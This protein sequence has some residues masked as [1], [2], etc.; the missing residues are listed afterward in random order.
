VWPIVCVLVGCVR[1]WGWQLV[2]LVLWEGW[3]FSWGL[4]VGVFGWCLLGFGWT[5]ML[6][7]R[8]AECRWC[9]LGVMLVL[10]LWG[11]GRRLMLCGFWEEVVLGLLVLGG[12][13]WGGGV[14]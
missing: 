7:G 13:L 3:W 11:C 14:V 6:G 9:G 8:G 4:W 12:D 2:G 5:G 1:V 10:D